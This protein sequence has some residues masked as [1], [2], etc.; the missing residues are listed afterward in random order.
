VVIMK[1]QK[2]DS[3]C[4]CRKT[5]GFYSMNKTLSL[6]FL[7]LISV[8]VFAINPNDLNYVTPSLLDSNSMGAMLVQ[9]WAFGSIDM[10]FLLLSVITC[11]ILLK[12]G[13]PVSTILISVMGFAAVFAF[14]FNS[15][16]A[17][18]ILIAGIILISLMTVIN[19]LLKT[20]Y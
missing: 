7:L 10:A 12:Y 13:I 8:S 5:S 4:N 9:E 2:L 14:G 18:G 15:L 3:F 1:E 6:L 17:W 11:I 16:I 19:L 20:W